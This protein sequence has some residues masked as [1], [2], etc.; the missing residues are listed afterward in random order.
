MI[1]SLRAGGA[2]R[3]MS[4]VAQ[5]L[6]QELFETTLVVIGSKN[7]YSYPIDTINLVFLEKSRVLHSFLPI[8][9]LLRKQK[10]DIVISAI[11]H[12]NAI[13]AFESIFFKKIIFI[14]RE[15]NVISV[16]SKIQSSKK[17]FSFIDFTKYSYKL[18][19]II[20]CQ[21][22][23]MANDMQMNFDVSSKKIRIINNPISESFVPKKQMPNNTVPKF[24]TVGSLVER[25]GHMRILKALLKYNEPFEYTMIGDGNKVEEVLN[26]AKENNIGENVKHIPFTKNVSDYLKKSDIFLQGSY[27]EGFPNAL[28]ESCATGTPAIVYKALGGIDEIIEEGVNGYIAED[29]VEFVEKLNLLLKQKLEPE[30]VSSSVMEKFNSPK[31][32]KKY[33]NLFLELLQ[34]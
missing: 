15:V 32:L 23:D 28:L 19:D 20:L 16:L 13:M 5:N 3:V 10:P 30:V 25:K 33:E 14:G 6:S 24:I 21:S 7:D 8:F 1:P 18:L 9:S 26:F 27:V 12:V 17:W 2:E 22:K 29:E 34:K 4:F 31:I 11:G